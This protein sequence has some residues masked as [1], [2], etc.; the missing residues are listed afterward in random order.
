MN[1]LS[2]EVSPKITFV[3]LSDTGKGY[4]NTSKLNGPRSEFK[5]SIDNLKNGTW[6][7]SINKLYGL[8]IR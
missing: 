5:L 2:Q 6:G 8:Y 7:W 3:L 1:G 4:F